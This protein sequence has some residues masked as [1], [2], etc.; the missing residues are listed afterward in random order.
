MSIAV[1]W[2]GI[3]L[4]HWSLFSFSEV[5]ASP[6]LDVSGGQGVPVR[7]F[8]FRYLALQ[9]AAWEKPTMVVVA[10]QGP[11]IVIISMSLTHKRPLCPEK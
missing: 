6:R 8:S 2:V 9:H 11:P 5:S 7:S 3:G 4:A 10:V 1:P